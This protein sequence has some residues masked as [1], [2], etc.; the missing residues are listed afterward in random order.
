ML[1]LLQKIIKKNITPNQLLL[2]YAL[3][4][5]LSFPQINPHLEIKGLKREGYIVMNEDIESGCEI[6]KSGRKI[7]IDF[8]NY[9][10]KAKKITSIQ[11][12]GKSYTVAV[13]NYR[14]MFPKMK[15][16]SGK[17]ARVNIKTLI[18]CF[19]WFFTNYNYSWEEIYKATR[20][21][22][23][24]YE[25]NDYMYMKTSQYFIVK[26]LP[27]KEKVS[28]LA[29]YCDMIREGVEEDDNSPFKERVV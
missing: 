13:Q 17:P 26:T 11:L 29:D 14:K 16:P 12:M 6:T 24:E 4:D 2:L 5:S 9:F 23:N 3:D 22:L 27:T 8:N 28:D 15:L 7:M 18:D 20:R 1:E 19:R 21:Y 10:V 25:D